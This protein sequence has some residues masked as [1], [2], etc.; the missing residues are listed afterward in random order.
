MMIFKIQIQ[1]YVLYIVHFDIFYILEW[2]KSLDIL[3]RL[4]DNNR[5]SARMS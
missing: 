2:Q 3:P 1:V 4:F 5:V